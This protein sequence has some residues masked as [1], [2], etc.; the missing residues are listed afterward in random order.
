MSDL[1]F[2]S[3]AV[4]IAIGAALAA[5]AVLPDH[6]VRALIVFALNG[7]FVVSLAFTNGL[8]GVFSLGHVAFIA[9]GAYASGI[10]SLAPATKLALLPK[11][12]LLLAG[13]SLDFVPSC[14]A[15]GAVAAAAALC[16]GWPVLRLSGHY[17]SVATL[18]LLVIVN[19]V[20]VNAKDIT[21]GA[22]TFTGVPTDTTLPWAVGA[23]AVTLIVL[24]RIAASPTGR[25]L[26][27]VREDPIAAESVGIGV[28]P[29]RLFA[30]VTAA[31]FAGCGGGF[32]A[33]YLGS[34][35]PATFGY[36][37]TFSLI[38]MLVVGGMRSL[39]GALAGV[40]VV[41]LLSEVLRNVE[42]GFT[43]GALE[44]P[45]LFGASQIVLGLVL[46]I[47]MIARPG[48]LIGDTEFGAHQ[49]RRLFAPHRQE[50]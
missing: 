45:A 10:T 1:V 11:L 9:L 34:F 40:A 20:L 44:V 33:H 35:S 5:P 15:G 22:R 2:W 29:M 21:R 32:Y 49:V 42:R 38:A 23:L 12:P 36:P 46:I 19:V 8:T 3:V 50:T 27:A 18:G 48:G 6:V 24:G 7:V 26:R 25:A 14:L 30:F 31:F 4:A 47:V 39:T 37:L 41:T 17:V 16:V 43:L 13:W 28:R